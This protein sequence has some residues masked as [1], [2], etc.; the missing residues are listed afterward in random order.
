CRAR[1]DLGNAFSRGLAAEARRKAEE[2]YRRLLY[3]GMTRAE[4]R[5]AV[6]GY[7]GRDGQKPGS[8]HAMVHEALAAAPETKEMPHPAS[9][10][11][12][13]RFHVAGPRAPVAAGGAEAA[14]PAPPT[15]MPD[16][17]FTP[18]PPAPPLPRPLA[19]SGAMAPI[20]PAP[21]MPR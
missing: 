19:P 6:C 1:A 11:T 8:W 15:P 9:G 3:V 12:I 17:L 2:E 10:E 21:D 18:L 20:E 5:L 16:V 14:P 7:H 4:D 13:L